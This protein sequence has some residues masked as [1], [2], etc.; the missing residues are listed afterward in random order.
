MRHTYP[1]LKPYHHE[2][3]DVGNG[4]KL[5]LEQSGNP[6]GIP[7]IYLHGGPGAGLTSLYRSFFNPEIYHIIGFD[8]RGCGKSMPFA[9]LEHNTTDEILEDIQTIRKHLDIDKWVVSGG[10]WGA[11]LALLCAI[12]H[13]K[14]VKGIILRGTFLARQEDFDWYL[15]ANGGPAQIYP[16]HYRDFIKPVGNADNASDLIGRYHEIFSNGN[17]IARTAAAKAWT[18]WEERIATLNS[19]VME[20]DLSDNLH[21]AISLALFEC[22]YILNKCFIDENYILE[23]IQKISSI[24]GTIIHGRYDMVCKLAGAYKLRDS[25][26]NSQLF[27]IP[28]SGHSSSEPL[29][30]EALCH[31]TDAMAK[32][33][34]EDNK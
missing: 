9:H 34:K 30:S 28:E 2:M 14:T 10:S 17:E 29:I 12:K 7:V 33:L 3:L 1:A 20:Q 11:T 25:W 18:L 26:R 32:F 22:H 13:P 27:I 23:N 24:P 4:H 16:E 15:A 6:D 8:Q 21:R 19:S 5:Y 31:A